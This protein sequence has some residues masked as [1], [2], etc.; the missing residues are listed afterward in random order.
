MKN[1]EMI[2]TLWIQKGGFNT[3]KN[4]YQDVA[5]IL[6]CKGRGRIK[7]GRILRIYVTIDGDVLTK[8]ENFVTKSENEITTGGTDFVRAKADIFV[9]KKEKK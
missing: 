6:S 3:G 7:H 8:L 1:R 5:I 4:Y 2:G 9:L